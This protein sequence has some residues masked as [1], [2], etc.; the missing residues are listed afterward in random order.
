M[1]DRHG[2]RPQQYTVLFITPAANTEWVNNM[3]ILVIDD[4]RFVRA[5]LAYALETSHQS[6]QVDQ[7]DPANGKPGSG[8]PWS[9]YDVL[10]M[11]YLLA[12]GE[13]GINWYRDFSRQQAMPPAILV[14]GSNDQ[15]IENEAL[16]AGFECV[17][18]K[19]ENTTR[20]VIGATLKARIDQLQPEHE[21]VP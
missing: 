6:V 21:S 15:D 5:Q 9:R 19:D 2:T 16:A 13:D 3:R 12:P 8:F 20:N 1:N 7:L 17:V 18:R 4:S 14:T 11:D 10:V